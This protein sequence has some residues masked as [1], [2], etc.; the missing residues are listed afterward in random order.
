MNKERELLNRCAVNL[1]D[2]DICPLLLKEVSE[3]LNEPQQE[4]IAWAIVFDAEPN[5]VCEDYL[6]PYKEDLEVIMEKGFCKGDIPRL[7]P[8]YLT[9]ETL[10]EHVDRNK[11]WYNIGYRVAKE[12][13]LA[14]PKRDKVDFQTLNELGLKRL[15]VSD[16]LVLQESCAKSPTL[17]FAENGNVLEIIKYNKLLEIK[18]FVDEIL[19]YADA[20]QIGVDDEH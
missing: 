10:R 20:P 6:S 19:N 2:R 4:P 14:Q 12:E 5:K 8:L 7:R 11:E 9:H 3:L 17:I 1:K 18:N 15:Q 13:L 16:N